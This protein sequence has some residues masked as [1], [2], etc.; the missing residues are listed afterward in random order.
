MKITRDIDPRGIT[1]YH[2]RRVYDLEGTY[3]RLTITQDE[4]SK[5]P[6]NVRK[7]LCDRWSQVCQ[8]YDGYMDCYL[9][10][11]M[12]WSFLERGFRGTDFTIQIFLDYVK[13]TT[14]QEWAVEG[15]R[16]WHLIGMM[17]GQMGYIEGGSYKIER[18]SR[19][20]ISVPGEVYGLLLGSKKYQE[21]IE[22]AVKAFGVMVDVRYS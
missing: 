8:I 11:K 13:L 1:H 18:S 17:F 6:D 2:N 19:V 12:R 15:K 9:P 10:P 14:S 16:A 20:S 5:C 21:K 7:S 4:F 3:Y 22:T